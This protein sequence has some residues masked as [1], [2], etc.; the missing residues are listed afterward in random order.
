MIRQYYTLMHLA[1][2]LNTTLKGALITECFT[3][4]KNILI[5]KCELAN[6]KD[7][8][9]YYIECSLDGDYSA[10][11][12]RSNFS[13]AKHNVQDKFKLII[14]E[15]IQ[16]VECVEH[17]RIIRIHCQYI[18]LHFLMFTGVSANILCIN[19]ADAL[20]DVFRPSRH[21]VVGDEYSYT[22]KTHLEFHNAGDDI[23]LLKLLTT[24]AFLF[25]YEYAR[26]VIKSSN[27]SEDILYNSLNQQQ[28]REVFQRALDLRDELVNT[29]N[30]YVLSNSDGMLFL[31]L[32]DKIEGKIY[33]IE[34]S[35]SSAIKTVLIHRLQKR[36]IEHIRSAILDKSRREVHRLQKAVDNMNN[37]SLALRKAEEHKLWAE[38]LLSQP[39]V[40]T[41]GIVSYS[42]NDW[43]GNELVIPLNPALNLAKN[44]ELYFDKVR[45][46]NQSAKVRAERKPM[47]EKKIQ[48]YNSVIEKAELLDDAKQLQA[49][50]SSILP[51]QPKGLLLPN[52]QQLSKKPMK[53]NQEMNAQSAT[54]FRTFELEEGFVVYVGKNAENNDRLTMKFA[55]Q[56]DIWLHARGVGGS[57]A[58]LRS[59]QGTKPTK[60]FIEQAAQIS[61]YYSQ[62]RNA[63]YT[64]VVYTERKYVRKPKGANVGAVVLERETVIMVEPKLPAGSVDKD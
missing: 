46:A 22:A 34:H 48:E 47:Y 52:K 60:K 28:Q 13:K 1:K 15:R 58:I 16:Q 21:Y 6:D 4:D 18:T 19:K 23:T 8:L 56:N 14:G 17:D 54:Q 10:M 44:A 36:K 29:N 9:E 33:I 12:L 11:Y 45:R 27:L 37:D 42:T 32:S 5:L 20:L 55:K 50:Y 49:L 53:N 64:P 63:K 39:N 25:S 26:Y 31:S 7:I 59:T 3:Q 43:D 24:S 57:H 61:A 38:I 35:I 51:N 41:N 62:S 40:H 30:Y 2:E